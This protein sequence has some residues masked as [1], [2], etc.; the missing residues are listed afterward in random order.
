[1]IVC[2]SAANTPAYHLRWPDSELAS[3]TVE[4]PGTLRLRLAAAFCH[5]ALD[6]VAGYLQPVE[7]VFHGATWCGDDPV[8]CLGGIA[9]GRLLVDGVPSGT[10]AQTVPLPLD[11]R[12]AVVCEFRLI[13]G[14]A[15]RVEAQSVRV[16][17][18]EG[19]RFHESFAC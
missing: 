8:V 10:T 16:S 17:S 11:R 4:A 3:T 19:A 15:L 1:M 18:G 5:R 9:H 14:T 2:M 12:G 7:L 6:G 13:S